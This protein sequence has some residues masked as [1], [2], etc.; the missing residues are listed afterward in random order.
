MVLIGLVVGLVFQFTIFDSDLKTDLRTG[1]VISLKAENGLYICIEPN[2]EIPEFLYTYRAYKKENDED[3]KFR[4]IY[5][6][7]NEIAL[8][9]KF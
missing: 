2:H 4:V 8:L 3:C 7:R 5:L 9:G 6:G 1:D